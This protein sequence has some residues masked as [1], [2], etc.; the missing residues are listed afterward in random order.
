[1]A[2]SR[3][4]AGL[5]EQPGRPLNV[6]QNPSEIVAVIS[7]RG[8]LHEFESWAALRRWLAALKERP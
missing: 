6:T 7:F 4:T 5:R 8:K 1:V 3:K 2:Q